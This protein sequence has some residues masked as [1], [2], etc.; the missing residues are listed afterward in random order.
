MLYALPALWVGL[1]Y[2]SVALD[3]ALDLIRDWTADERQALRDA[4]PRT[5][6]KTPFR[7]RTV[8]DI[9]R[10][11]LA[12]ARGGLARRARRNREGADETVYLAPLDEIVAS[13]ET[14]AERLLAAYAGEWHGDIDQVFRR[15]AY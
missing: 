14:R 5:A 11:V 9:A 1:L 8:R 2:D 13:G 6:L 4:V 7:N 15:D 3:P 10:D 12:I